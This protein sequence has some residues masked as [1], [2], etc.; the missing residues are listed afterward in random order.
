MGVSVETISG[1]QV[2]VI[3]DQPGWDASFNKEVSDLVN[4]AIDEGM[5]VVLDLE[6]VRN[7]NSCVLGSIVMWRSHAIAKGKNLV[8]CRLQEQAKKILETMKLN[9]IFEV[10]PDQPTAI[11]RVKEGGR[12]DPGRK[13]RY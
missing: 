10:F 12:L 2:V 9:L 8:L 4:D 1:V 11:Q 5:A 7:L 13:T 3:S 6:K